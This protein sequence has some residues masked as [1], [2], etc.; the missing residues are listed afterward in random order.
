MPERDYVAEELRHA[1]KALSDAAVL[2][3]SGTDAATVNRLYYACF[4]AASAVLYAKGHSSTTHRGVL[5]LS[6]QHVV[7]TGEVN[8][9]DGRFLNQMGDYRDQADYGYEPLDVN[10]EALFARTEDFVERLETLCHS[11]TDEGL[12]HKVI[13]DRFSASFYREHWFLDAFAFTVGTA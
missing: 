1:Q 10:V 12:H 9:D 3:D 2:R 6:D 4:H 11:L 13:T 7:Q 5:S 8:G